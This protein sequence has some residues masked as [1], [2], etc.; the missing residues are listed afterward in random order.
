MKALLSFV[1]ALLWLGAVGGPAQTHAQDNIWTGGVGGNWT[2]NFSWNFGEPP[3]ADFDSRGVIGTDAGSGSPIGEVNVTSDLRNS[4]KTPEIRLG[5]GVG[6]SGTLNIA[7]NGALHILSNGISTGNFDTGFDGGKG[8]LNVDGI[9]EIDGR[10]FAATEGDSASTVTLR[11]SAQ[12]TAG[13]A[14]LDQRFVVE[15]ANVNA[16]FNGNLVLGQGGVSTWRITPAGASTL[17]VGGNADLGGVLKVEFPSSVPSVG[18]VWNLIDSATVDN[19]ESPGSGFASID[20]STVRV[21]LGQRFALQTVA[22]GS[23]GKLTQ[24]ALEQH[25]VLVVDRSTGSAVIQNFG[26]GATVPFDAYVLSSS[27]GSLSPGGW[28]PIAG[29]WTTANPSA[30]ALSELHT[31]GSQSLAAGGSIDLGTPIS[32]AAPSS[33]GQNVE[34]VRF[35]F[36]KPDD[37]RF[38]EGTVLY[39]GASNSTLTLN[40]DP[41]TGEAQLLNGTDFT[42]AIDVYVVKSATNSLDPANG[43]WS[44]L[45]DQNAE[46]GLW[47][48]ANVNSG[49]ISELLVTGGMTLAPGAIVPLGTPFDAAN[50][51]RDLS[52]E[53]TVVESSAGN[54]NGDQRVDGADFLAWQRGESP[55]SGNAG[56]F[57]AWEGN[58]G[59]LLTGSDTHLLQGKVSYGAMLA[60]L[61]SG[62]LAAAAVP[63]PATAA[64]FLASLTLLAGRRRR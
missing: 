47:H 59:A 12:V 58:F 8:F 41:N 57:A 1:A 40:V 46:S 23:N 9:L 11:G 34:D 26:S 42:V 7:S 6:Q 35:R 2:D 38:T 52:F 13:S 16:R 30:N 14:F 5:D 45:D 10:L 60:S 55:N 64:I 18:Q 61:G 50:G 56:D 15:G 49:V 43:A 17:D 62:T 20:Q 29:T 31:S 53:F 48:E 33:F 51:I 4:Q 54:F 63:E 32:Y 25:P 21:E 19:N 3:N 44:S 37:T 22:G 39:T 28:N 24:L 36:A 27:N